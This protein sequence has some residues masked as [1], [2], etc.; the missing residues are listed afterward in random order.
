MMEVRNNKLLAI[1]L[2]TSSSSHQKKKRLRINLG[3]FSENLR[4]KTIRP[5]LV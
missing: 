5:E 1:L 2:F 3:D 4:N